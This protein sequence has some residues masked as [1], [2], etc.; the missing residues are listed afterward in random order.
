MSYSSTPQLS[1]LPTLVIDA[2]G[3]AAKQLAD[4]L[5]RSGFPADIAINRSAAEAAR[6]RRYYGSIVFVGDLS[7]PA[8]LQSIVELR[9]KSQRTW[10]IAISSTRPPEARNEIVR[11]EADALLIAPFSMKDLISRLFAFSLRSRPL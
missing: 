10:I 6:L 3:A 7:R 2:N 11:R 1:Y 5:S 4:Q 9:K 8:D